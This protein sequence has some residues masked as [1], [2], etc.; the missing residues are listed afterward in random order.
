MSCL[1]IIA[2]FQSGN[3]P[4]SNVIDHQRRPIPIIIYNVD[5]VQETSYSAACQHH[6]A[7][8]PTQTPSRTALIPL[9][10][11]C[12]NNYTNNYTISF[13]HHHHYA[14]FAFLSSLQDYIPLFILLLTWIWKPLC[15]YLYSLVQS[16]NQNTS[17]YQEHRFRRAN[18]VCTITILQI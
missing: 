18:F 6:Y 8:P 13:S 17:I 10:Q 14:A 2:C 15:H 1:V 9:T 12:T 4:Q 11:P 16:L 5:Y 7:M 3:P